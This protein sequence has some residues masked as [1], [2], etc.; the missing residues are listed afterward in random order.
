M[1]YRNYSVANGFIVDKLGNGD[2]TTIGAALTAASSGD[3]IFIRP[4][5]YTENPALKAGV[6]LSAMPGDDNVGN[7]T[8]LG[9]CTFSSAGSVAINNIQ[10][11]T[12]SNYVLSVTGSVASVVTLNGCY[13]DLT[14]NTG[15]QYT[16]SSSSSA[17]TLNDCAGGLGT[18]GIA[19]FSSSGAGSINFLFCFFTNTGSSTTS[20]TS[21]AGAAA[22]YYCEIN[23][24]I[25][26][27]STSGFLSDYTLFSTAALNT[28]T[29][30]IGGSG[31]NGLTCCQVM[32]GTATA[33]SIGSTATVSNCD[34]TSSNTNAIAGAGTIS[35]SVINFIGSSKVISTSTQDPLNYGTWTPTVVGGTTGGTTTYNTQQGYYTRV[36][37]LIYVEGFII[38]TAATGTGNAVFSLPFTVKNLSNYNPLGSFTSAS[39]SWSW[40]GSGTQL[41][42][43]PQPNT[44]T[45]LVSSLKSDGAT[46]LAMTNGS[47]TF[48]F[49]VWYQI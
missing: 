34:I 5:T 47:A 10:L 1:A 18:T 11:E 28:T 14:N 12:N 25:T 41:N 17:I 19:I 22:F 39:T 38:I 29:L 3:T 24:P 4:G 20:S 43:L 31:Q 26:T 21:S 27:S 33:I 40:T 37:N 6:N 42:L 13:L 49:S 48:T 15:I 7:V 23:S 16:S 9:E 35:Y 46:D 30:T 44:T 2:F 32:A 8:I 45:A 36:G